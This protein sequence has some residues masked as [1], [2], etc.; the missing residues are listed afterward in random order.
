MQ[1]RIALPLKQLDHLLAQLA[2]S[3]DVDLMPGE[4]DPTNASHPQQPFNRYFE[5]SMKFH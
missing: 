4:T 5:N 1:E 2:T 3:V